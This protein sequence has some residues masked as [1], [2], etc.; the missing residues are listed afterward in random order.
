MTQTDFNMKL[1]NIIPVEQVTKDKYFDNIK[2]NMTLG[3]P[4]I[5]HMNQWLTVNNKP[6]ALV[7][8][9]PSLK[10]NLDDLKNFKGSVVA[11]GSCYDYLVLNGT[12]PTYAVICDPDKVVINYLRRKNPRTTFLVATNC[13]PEVFGYL[14]DMPIVAWHCYNDEPER[15]EEIDPNCY[16]IGGGCTVGLRAITIFLMLG[17]KDLHMFGFDS[18]ISQSG[19]EHAYSYSEAWEQPK[20]QYQ[21]KLDRD[22]DHYYTCLGY[23]LAQNQCFRDFTVK[24]YDYFRCHFHGGG[25]LAETYEAIDKAIRQ[26][27]LDQFR[28]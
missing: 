23:H 1:E 10:D 4:F 19:D 6:V 14:K 25:L 28:K 5:N 8:G 2:K 3:H 22:K 24:Y 26:G 21:V 16:A 11:C 20:D 17:H 12:I 7:G 18:C 15:F 9:G 13:D 27:K